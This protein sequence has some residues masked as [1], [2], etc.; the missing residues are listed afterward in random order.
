M[1]YFSTRRRVQDEAVQ[2]SPFP[3]TRTPNTCRHI[4]LAS[5]APTEISHPWIIG[6]INHRLTP[7]TRINKHI[8][9]RDTSQIVLRHRPK[10][11]A[12]S[13]T[14]KLPLSALIASLRCVRGDTRQG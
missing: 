2:I 5:Y 4:P 8:R 10:R 12:S 7:S 14:L 11:S 9:H 1:V 6:G 13:F 3:G